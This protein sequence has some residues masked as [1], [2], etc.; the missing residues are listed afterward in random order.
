MAFGRPGA[1]RERG[2]CL[3]G[4]DAGFS[5]FLD[6]PLGAVIIGGSKSRLQRARQ[7]VGQCNQVHASGW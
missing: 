4:S 7:S 2:N 1:G 6:L 3:A 5:F